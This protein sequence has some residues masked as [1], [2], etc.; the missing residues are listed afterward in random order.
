MN[1]KT[2]N[3]IRW[4]GRLKRWCINKT[5]TWSRSWHKWWWCCQ[6]QLF[7]WRIKLHVL[8]YKRDHDCTEWFLIFLLNEYIQMFMLSPTIY[9]NQFTLINHVD[10]SLLSIH[11][12]QFAIRIMNIVF[13][14]NTFNYCY[15]K[16]LMASKCII[17]SMISVF[18]Y[19]TKFF[20]ILYT[21]LDFLIFLYIF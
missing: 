12:S 13:F 4:W 10:L 21:Q 9:L 20:A 5:T 19:R 3:G 16:G 8:F 7:W 11:V 6:P 15:I 14:E 17:V 18:I 2:A 1:A